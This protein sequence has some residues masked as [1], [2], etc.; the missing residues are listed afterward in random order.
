M[1]CGDEGELRTDSLVIPQGSTWGMKW[2]VVEVDG[3]TPY[4]LT[5]WS[6]RAQVRPSQKSATVLHE[7]SAAL[8]NAEVDGHHVVLRVTPD[9][10]S[11]WEWSRGDFDIELTNVD[12]RVVRITQGQVRVDR[13]VTRD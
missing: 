5:G 11:S 1:S 7:W 4:D 3:V 13:E 8:G 2:P 10:S 9:E 12:G 6:P